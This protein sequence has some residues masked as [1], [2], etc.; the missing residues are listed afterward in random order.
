[1]CILDHCWEDLVG[2]SEIQQSV[3]RTEMSSVFSL[4]SAW[5]YVSCPNDL[6]DFPVCASLKEFAANTWIGPESQYE[7]SG[8]DHLTWACST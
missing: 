1:M 2:G 4:G 6:E 5:P 8:E 7:V 3:K